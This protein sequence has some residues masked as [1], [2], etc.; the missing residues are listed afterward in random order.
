MYRK[1][2]GLTG[3][4]LPKNA[5]GKSFFDK[6]P[7]YLRLKRRFA[8][9]IEDPGVGVLVGDPGVGK[10]ASIRNLCVQ[11]PKPDYLVLYLCD[12]QVSSLDIY[13]S[14]A[15]ELGLR[16]SH[17]RGQL[18]ADIKQ[19][20]CHMV[21]ERGIQPVLVI[22]QAQ[23]LAE[24]FLL[25]LVSLL[26]V[27]FD[28]RQVLTLWLVGLP[29]LLRRL[30]MI[31]LAS[32]R[33]MVT[34]EVHLEP[35]D[36]EAFAALVDHAL[37]AAGATNNLLSDPAR[38]LLFRSSRGVPRIASKLLRS[39]LARAHERDQSFVDDHTIEAVLDD[40]APQRGAA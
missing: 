18:A 37:K 29:E 19:A 21:D 33:M 12:T 39:A 24:S 35:L 25:D 9:L 27:S 30:G 14:L 2:F 23:Q 6:S 13:R 3:H 34:A 36:R 4:P 38:E 11:L 1:R 5:Q 32:L 26:N 7:G 22:D 20:L 10:T 28:S 31:Q 16:P 40:V 8:D 17:R 15:R